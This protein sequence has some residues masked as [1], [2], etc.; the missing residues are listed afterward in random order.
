[1][2]TK[3][4][5]KILSV[6]I[7]SAIILLALPIIVA[8]TA[9]LFVPDGTNSFGTVNEGVTHFYNITINITSLALAEN[10][11]EVN[12]TL[13]YGFVFDDGTNRTNGDSVGTQSKIYFANTSSVL[14]WNSTEYLINTTVNGTGNLTSFTFNAT[15]AH[16][17]HFSNPYN[18][19]VTLK[20]S[21][22]STTYSY[23]NV[24]INDTTA[25][26]V[27]AA[28]STSAVNS[29]VVVATITDN[30]N[31]T[32]L[33]CISDRDGT[34]NTVITNGN[35]S[36]QTLTETSLNCGGSYDY[37]FT[38]T[39]SNGNA[40]FSTKLT[41]YTSNCT[42]G[43]SAAAGSSSG[44]STTTTVTTFAVSTEQAEAGYQK[45]LAS[46]ERVKVMVGNEYHYV[47]VKS[48]SENSATIEVASDP[49]TLSL[50][51]GESS[52]VDVDNDGIYDLY[53]MLNSI[54]DGK[55]DVTVQKISEPIPEGEGPVS[56][57]EET[58]SEET[59]EGSNLT[60]LWIVIGI[61]IVLA[62]IGM[63]MKKKK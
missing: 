3:N 35:T 61:V 27:T 55:A 14:T 7:F 16:P 28:V 25:P 10:V 26:N 11:T 15:A 49:V 51:V 46:N 22:D 5:K 19:T 29:L 2:V 1:M 13:P 12:I 40:G 21:T 48:I 43:G 20:N 24:S 8:T 36:S 50:D 9:V 60:W 30:H 42:G 4:S 38:C 62:I 32:S 34:G 41:A 44:S 58:S 31:V 37:I 47:T 18:F 17:S 23:L 6:V 63:S 53:V 45:T 56:G 39:D 57:N 54:T 52:K 33:T 59:G